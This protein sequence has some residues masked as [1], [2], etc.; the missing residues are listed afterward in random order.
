MEISKTPAANNSTITLTINRYL[1]LFGIILVLVTHNECNV[2]TAKRLQHATTANKR[3]MC[4]NNKYYP[5]D[6]NHH[7]IFYT[8]PVRR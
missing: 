1:Y 2:S 6:D 7:A 3:I 4:L 8:H 5:H